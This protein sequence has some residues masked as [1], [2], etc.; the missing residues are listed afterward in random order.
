MFDF[1]MFIGLW[2]TKNLELG[3]A[4]ILDLGKEVNNLPPAGQ[5]SSLDAS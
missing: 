1:L 2:P 5:G 3:T 4:D